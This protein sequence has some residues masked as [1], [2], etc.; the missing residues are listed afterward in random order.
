MEG[1]QAWV[2]TVA[3]GYLRKYSEQMVGSFLRWLGCDG[4]WEKADSFYHNFPTF[5]EVLYWKLL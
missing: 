2:L 1:V 3:M 5:L 4:V